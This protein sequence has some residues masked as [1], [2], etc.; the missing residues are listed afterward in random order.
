MSESMNSYF[1]KAYLFCTNRAVLAIDRAEVH[2]E[3]SCRF[4]TGLAI[5]I[6]GIYAGFAMFFEV[7]KK[8]QDDVEGGNLL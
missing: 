5:L 6:G 1:K 3:K 4:R 7:D 2:R 8:W